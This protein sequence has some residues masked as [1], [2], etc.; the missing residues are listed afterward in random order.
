MRVSGRALKRPA[1]P[2]NCRN[3]KIEIGSSI[4][5]IGVF[6]DA[7]APGS[8]GVVSHCSQLRGGLCY[9][10]LS[11]SRTVRTW[12]AARSTPTPAAYVLGYIVTLLLRC[13]CCSEQ[14]AGIKR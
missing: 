9:G 4:P 3:G 11:K 12:V 10:A 7:Q 1:G 14:K 2:H 8:R 13:T 6:R 5:G